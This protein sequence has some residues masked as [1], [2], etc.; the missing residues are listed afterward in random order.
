MT[1]ATD[2]PS[3]PADCSCS[4]SSGHAATRLIIGL[5]MAIPPK[6]LLFDLPRRPQEQTILPYLPA[7][8]HLAAMASVA[9]AF[10]TSLSVGK[11]P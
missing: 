7:D 6:S 3:Q 4:I 11:S 2:S 1:A 5:S 9:R 10:R 8:P